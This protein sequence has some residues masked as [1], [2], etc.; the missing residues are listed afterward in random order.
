MALIVRAVRNHPSIFIGAHSSGHPKRDRPG[1]RF[2][3]GKMT[4]LLQ[5]RFAGFECAHRQSKTESEAGAERESA[6]VCYDVLFPDRSTGT[7]NLHI[8]EKAR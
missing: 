6:K 3:P 8:K 7:G 4:L 2:R 1:R 5:S